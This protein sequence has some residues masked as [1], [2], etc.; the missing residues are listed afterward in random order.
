MPVV[1]VCVLL[2]LPLLAL[3]AGWL[4]L[5]KKELA[6]DAYLDEVGA[7]LRAAGLEPLGWGVYRLEGKFV[8]VEAGTN[9]LLSRRFSVRIAA[10]SD[11]VHEFEL[12]RGAKPP[13]E[14]EGFAPL[15]E[16][17]DSAGKFNLECYA[18]G[19][20]SD[21]ELLPDLKLLAGL[22]GQPLAKPCRGKTFTVREG[23][24]AKVPQWHWRHDQRPRLPD[25][26]HRWCVSYWH[27]D[28]YLNAGLMKLFEALAGTRR[29][30][31]IS[32]AED[33]SFAE[34][35]FGRRGLD[36]HGTLVEL[37]HAA[38]AIGADRTL[39]GEFFGG[40][41]AAGE[42]PAGW[43]DVPRY[44]FH[45]RAIDSIRQVHFYARRLFDEEFSWYSGEYEILSVHPLDV[46]GALT[47]VAEELGAQVLE[48]DRRFHKRIVVPLDW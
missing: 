26:T 47:R 24:E 30:F 10:W 15:L 33:L 25:G 23:F 14:F 13:Y 37:P 45:D 35:A 46:R 41:L 6:R 38:A 3:L 18:A 21:P 32:D 36:V 42:V 17:W 11:T 19:V 28:P 5:K 44:R 1:A 22:A 2:G 7:R 4:R 43:D 8:K 40:L 29:K 39:D 27:G 31:Y 20:R 48:I 34:Y 16:R 12:R 9:P